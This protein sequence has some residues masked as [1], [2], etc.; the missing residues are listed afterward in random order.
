TLY[1]DC[2]DYCK[3]CDHYQCI[4]KPGR[5][6]EMPLHHIPSM[7]PFEKWV[8]DFVGPIAPTTRRIGSRYVI[9]CTDYLGRWAEVAPTK[10]YTTATSA[11]FLWDNIIT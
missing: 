8:I 10:D 3:A 6:D 11:R 9:T 4:S 7:E 5:R 2:R 1:K